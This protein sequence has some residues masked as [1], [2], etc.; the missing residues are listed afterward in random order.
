MKT[1]FLRNCRAVIFFLTLFVAIGV[2]PRV[3]A[4]TPTAATLIAPTGTLPPSQPTFRWSAEGATWYFLW[5]SKDGSPWYTNW[6]HTNFWTP[7]STMEIGYYQWWV[8]TWNP[9][10]YGPW[11]ATGAFTVE[12]L[13]NEAALRTA[14]NAGGTYMFGCDGTITLSSPLVVSNNLQLDGNG[15]SVTISGGHTGMVFRVMPGISLTLKNVT[16][17]DGLAQAGAGLYNDGGTVN[18]LSCGFYGNI[19]TNCYPQV[20]GGA[21]YNASG[22]LNISNCVFSGNNSHNVPPVTSP[23]PSEAY[24]GCLYINSG[25]VTI[26][27]SRFEGNTVQGSVGKT[28]YGQNGRSGFGG[29]I[30]NAG[31][32]MVM[33]SIFAANQAFG[34]NGDPVPSSYPDGTSGGY[35]YGGAIYNV[36]NC[37]VYRSSFLANN[38][39]GGICGYAP[40]EYGS[41][42]GRGG[43]GGSGIGGGIYQ[44]SNSFLTLISCTFASNSVTGSAGTAGADGRWMEGGLPPLHGGRGGDGGS[45]LGG[46]IYAESG[47]VCM[48]NSTFAGNRAQAGNA[49]AGGSFAPG[50]AGGNGGNAIGGLGVGGAYVT[51]VN[52]SFGWNSSASGTGAAGAAGGT[53]GINGIASGGLG[54]TSGD[55]LLGNSL[56]AYCTPTNSYGALLDMGHNISS[57]GSCGFTTP[58]SL[59]NVDPNLFPLTNNGGSTLTMGLMAG[60]AAIDAADES[61]AP[62]NDQ[63]GISRPVGAG[64]DIGA[65][66]YN[67]PWGPLDVSITFSK[68]PV[69][70]GEPVTLQIRILNTNA[71]PLSSIAITNFLPSAMFIAPTSNITNLC[72]GTLHALSG[73][74]S[75]KGYGFALASGAECTISL[76]ETC[77]TPGEWSSGNLTVATPETGIYYPPHAILH[78]AT[79]PETTTLAASCFFTNAFTLNA[80]VNP[81]GA[82]TLSFFEWGLTTNLGNLTTARNAGNGFSNTPVE[83]VLTNLLPNAVYYYRSVASN[84]YGARRG[85]IL[86]ASTTG[87]VV[88][89]NSEAALR[90][91]L[92][93][94]GLI[95]FGFDGTISLSETLVISQNTT[96]DGS[97][98]SVVLSGDG[99]VRVFEVSTNVTLTLMNMTIA[100]GR[101]TNGGG[102]LNKGTVLLVN[103]ILSNNHAIGLSGISGTNG[104]DGISGGSGT[105][106]TSGQSGTPGTASYG[107]AIY[108]TG[109]LMAQT[110]LF[111]GN[112]AE[113]GVG[114]NGGDGGNGGSGYDPYGRCR[115]YN[116]GGSGGNGGNGASGYG[117]RVL[118]SVVQSC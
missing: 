13:C 9:D 10:G 68:N 76:D 117:G 87:G 108:N 11:S 4:A 2:L 116:T 66:E 85:V 98:H 109:T 101:S 63:R 95:V 61:F 55:L 39:A 91:N 118:S 93:N 99:A 15:H 83:I 5:I 18:L 28:G 62:F 29:A 25:I 100:D 114:G 17:A 67:L 19:A 44:G 46:A 104:I 90:A 69:I 97:G 49:G 50:G 84:V 94:G 75:F 80:A 26:T 73:S 12:S 51:S 60:S 113:G 41:Y 112:S 105:V 78:V 72:G 70:V 30:Y 102:I 14:V 106:G 54:R 89:T 7:A 57:D 21:V 53:N 1:L 96:L 20:K 35:G 48:T 37:W 47:F 92:A 6:I 23:D 43:T 81:N 77:S 71:A 115:V 45:G 40:S 34:G 33:S 56:V 65:Y 22:T 52:N 110:T 86:S 3:W 32:L 38:A 8:E 82:N 42:G 59:N 103:C 24:G 27:S 31:D 74:L 88:Q 111:I 58:G 79:I 36:G 16:V 64:S 107:G